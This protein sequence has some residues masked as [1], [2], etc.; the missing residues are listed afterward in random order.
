MRESRDNSVSRCVRGNED[1]PALAAEAR[2]HEVGE[3][4]DDR[5]QD[6][7][8]GQSVWTHLTRALPRPA[9]LGGLTR[10][11]TPFGGG[12]LRRP[13]RA[14]LDPSKMP[15]RN[16]RRVLHSDRL[17]GSLTSRQVNN[18]LG[19]LVRVAGH[20]GSLHAQRIAGGDA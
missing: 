2:S 13:S 18:G 16:R 9:G 6:Y 1:R 19:T 11:G 5:D 20:R 15:A 8:F 4:G 10:A 17:R 14:T 12:Q 3:Q 7:E